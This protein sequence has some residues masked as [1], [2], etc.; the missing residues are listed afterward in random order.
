MEPLVAG[1]TRLSHQLGFV[2]NGNPYAEDR[3]G[4]QAPA[5]AALLPALGL[6]AGGAALG[7]GAVAVGRYLDVDVMSRRSEQEDD[8]DEDDLAMEHKRA[9][10]TIAR[11]Q[12]DQQMRYRAPT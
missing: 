5:A 6:V 11:M 9:A 7:L 1:A 2:S 10:A 3:L 4:V 8:D 12:A